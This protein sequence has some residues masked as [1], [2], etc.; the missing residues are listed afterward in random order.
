MRLSRYLA[1]RPGTVTVT[2]AV[3]MV[4]LASIVAIAVDGG[5][6]LAERRHAQSTADS[7]ALAAATDLYD[8]YWA[9]N[10]ADPAGTAKASALAT[11]AANGYSND[12]TTSIVTVNI[13]PLSGPYTGKAGYTEVIV[14]Y[15]QT[16]AFSNIFSSG[17]I[18]VRARAVS[19]GS[20]VAANVGILVLDPTAKGAFSSNGGGAS[21]VSGTPIVVD[22]NNAEAAIAGGGGSQTA[23]DF[24]ITG[25]DATTGGGSFSGNIHTGQAPMNDPL[26]D[27]PPPTRPPCPSRATRR[28]STP[29]EPSTCSRASTRAASRS[30]APAR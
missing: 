30:A 5:T 6:L 29:G 8:N 3:C 9:N 22:S 7:A 17:P 23:P 16:R 27:I 10:G 26:A 13:P 18:P 11:A 2:A 25:G 12:G 14:E 20:P 19:L 15:H 28:C 21:N 1:R 24:Y 4:F